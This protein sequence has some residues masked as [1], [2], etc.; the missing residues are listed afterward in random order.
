MGKVKYNTI[1]QILMNPHSWTES[2][3]VEAWFRAVQRNEKNKRE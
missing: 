3:Q 1:T 2:E